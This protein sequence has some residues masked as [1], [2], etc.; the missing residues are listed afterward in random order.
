MYRDSLS[1][2]DLIFSNVRNQTIDKFLSRPSGS[3]MSRKILL[4]IHSDKKSW[5]HTITYNYIL[6]VYIFYERILIYVIELCNVE[7]RCCNLK[8]IFLHAF[9]QYTGGT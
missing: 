5:L 3:N 4:I 8:Q 2:Q 7:R 1:C 9:M 6:L